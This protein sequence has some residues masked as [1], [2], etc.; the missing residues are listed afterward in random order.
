MTHPIP[1]GE[2]VVRATGQLRS[3]GAISDDVGRD[4][5]AHVTTLESELEEARTDR[6]AGRKVYLTLQ[7]S[8][9]V[10]TGKLTAS[11]A[12][13]ERLREALRPFAACVFDDNGDFRVDASFADYDEFIAAYRA[14]QQSQA[15]P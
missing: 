3:F 13:V 6:E 9:A 5:L 12:E 11:Q 1:T 15:Q 14:L 10:L 4:L 7:Q 2:L 8:M